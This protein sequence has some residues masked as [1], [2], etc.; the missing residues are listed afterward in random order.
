MI[1][2]IDLMEANKMN[3][4]ADVK[5]PGFTGAVSLGPCLQTYSSTATHQASREQIILEANGCPRA[6]QVIRTEGVGLGIAEPI[7]RTLAVG[8]AFG[9]AL[10]LCPPP[11]CN[12]EQVLRIDGVCSELRG[13]FACPTTFVG[14]CV[15]RTGP[16]PIE[17]VPAPVPV[18]VPVPVP[19]PVTVPVP[20][21]GTTPV[22]GSSLFGG[23][24]S[25]LGEVVSGLGNAIVGFGGTVVDVFSGIG[26]AIGDALSNIPPGAVVVVVGAVVIGGIIYVAG[27]PITVPA[28]AVVLIIGGTVI[29]VGTENGRPTGVSGT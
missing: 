15:Q 20:T 16:G 11:F 9:Q 7:A 24:V 21:A 19:S 29:V 10:G 28:T 8:D 17:P 18:V 26:G 5:L 13:V 12:L 27:A 6:G 14:L 4:T 2:K 23:V 3:G 25:G 22:P 1:D